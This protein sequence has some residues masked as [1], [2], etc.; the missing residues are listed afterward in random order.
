VDTSVGREGVVVG[1]E[2]SDGGW[3]TAVVLVADGD[4]LGLDPEGSEP[5]PEHPEAASSKAAGSSSALFLIVP[6]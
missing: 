3:D 5:P 2:D 4:A 1:G 6:P